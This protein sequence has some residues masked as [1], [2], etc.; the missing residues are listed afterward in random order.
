[1]LGDFNVHTNS[2]LKY[3]SN[4]DDASLEAEDDN[5]LTSVVA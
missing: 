5:K 3:S 1:M 2:F 4:T